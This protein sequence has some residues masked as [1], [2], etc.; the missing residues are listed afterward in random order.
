MDHYQVKFEREDQTIFGICE[1]YHEDAKSAAARG[2]VIVSDAVLPVQYEVREDQIVD[3]PIELGRCNRKTDE[4]EGGDE[5]R[6]YV[7]AQFK[8]AKQLSDSL[9]GGVQVGAL[10]GVG[11]ADG[12]AW[13]VVTKVGKRTC[14]VE[15]RGFCIDRYYDHHFGSGGSFPIAEVARYV[16]VRRG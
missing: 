5:Y 2:E 16:S 10:F 8:I 6:N 11:V 1:T 15:W 12:I 13:Y 7:A 4:Y 14:R 9:P 3:I